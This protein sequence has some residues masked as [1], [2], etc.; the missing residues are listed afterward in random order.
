MSSAEKDA[1]VKDKLDEYGTKQKDDVKSKDEYSERLERIEKKVNEIAESREKGQPVSEKQT[2]K[3][4]IDELKLERNNLS[5]GNKKDALNKLI[6]K[7]HNENKKLIEKGLQDKAEENMA[8]IWNIFKHRESTTANR[9]TKNKRHETLGKLIEFLADRGKSLKDIT[10]QDVTDMS[11]S[12][13]GGWK[14][15]KEVLKRIQEVANS[16]YSLLE[17][18][19]KDF[20]LSKLPGAGQEGT[21]IQYIPEAN[22]L[23]K[24][25]KAIGSAV[26]KTKKFF[27]GRDP[28]AKGNYVDLDTARAVHYISMLWG[29]RGV[30]IAST[31][32]SIKYTKK[33]S[34][35]DQ[36][37][38]RLKDIKITEDKIIITL[39]D[40]AKA[41]SKNVK[42]GF[43]VDMTLGTIVIH[44]GITKKILGYD[45]YNIIKSLHEKRTSIENSKKGGEEKNPYLLTYTSF[46]GGKVLPLTKSQLDGIINNHFIRKAETKS[47][48]HTIRHMWLTSIIPKIANAAKLNEYQQLTLQGFVDKYMLAHDNASTALQR[49]K[50]ILADVNAPTGTA[51]TYTGKQLPVVTSFKQKMIMEIYDALQK[52]KLNEKKFEDI[53]KSNEK[54]FREIEG[55]DLFINKDSPFSQLPSR[56]SSIGSKKQQV[57]LS[58][59]R[60]A[61]SKEL[62]NQFIDQLPKN[63]GLKLKFL[64]GKEYAGEFIDGVIRLV[65]GKADLTTFFHENVH[66]LEA[67]VRDSGNKKL[68]KAW[69]R[70]E[71]TIGEWAKKNDSVR[72]NEFVR[73]YGDK[74]ANEYL[75]QLSAE[76]SLKKSQ[77]TTIGGR[78]RNW[79]KEL[80]SKVKSML[81]IANAKD[82]SRIFGSIA[83]KGFSTE[84][85]SLTGRKFSKITKGDLVDKQQIK[86]LE[87][88]LKD[89]GIKDI[90]ALYIKLATDL[91]MQPV[92]RD[93][94]TQSEYAVLRD[95]IDTVEFIVKSD[96]TY[97]KK[98]KPTW[99]QLRRDVASKNR[100]YGI[101]KETEKLI[102]KHIGISGGTMKNAS[103]MQMKRYLDILN[104]LGEPP[105]NYKTMTPDSIINSELAY[106][107]SQSDSKILLNPLV[108]RWM[109]PVDYVLRKLGASGVA[110]LMLDH[111][112]F[113]SGLKGVS[114]YRI[115]NAID[116][117]NKEYGKHRYH[118]GRKMFNDYMGYAMDKESRAGARIDG[119]GREFLE[120]ADNVKTSAEY[121]A[122]QEMRKMTDFFFDT[123]LEIGKATIKNPRQL[124]KWLEQNSKLYVQEYF[125]RVPTKEGKKYLEDNRNDENIVIR[126]MA[127]IVEAVVKDRNSKIDKLKS[128]YDKSKPTSIAKTKEYRKKIKELERERDNIAE[129]LTDKS[130][131]E[132]TKLRQTAERQVYDLGQLRKN[133]V[134]N[135]Y[136][137]KRVPRL[138]NVFKDGNGKEIF[139]YETNFDKV[140][141]R[142][143]NVMSNYLA[144]AKYFPSFTNMRSSFIKGNESMQRGNEGDLFAQHLKVLS[145]E[146]SMQGAY[147][148]LAVKKRIGLAESDISNKPLDFWLNQAGRYSAM[149]GLSSPMSGLKNLVIGTTNTIGIF[150]MSNYLK[151]IAFMLG[152][153]SKLVKKELQKLGAGEIGTK[154]IELT[155]F[156]DFIMRNISKMKPTEVANRF[157]SAW[158]GLLTAEQLV[159]R[160]RGDRLGLFSKMRAESARKEL[161]SKFELSDKE[162]LHLQNHG[163]RKGQHGFD[164]QAANSLNAK[165][166]AI[167]DKILHY[168]HIITQ[169]AT[170]EPFLPLWAANN[171]ISSLTLFYRMAYSGTYNIM[172]HVVQPM[173]NGNVLPMARY[174]F[175]GQVM[176]A[177]LWAIYDSIMGNPPPKINES[178]L[179]RFSVNAAKA[180][181]LGLFGF[182][183]SPFDQSL[184]SDSI[185][186]PAIIRNTNTVLTHGFNAFIA[187]FAYKMGLKKKPVDSVESF[188]KL[189][190]DMV[191]L[192][193]HSLR[194]LEKKNNPYKTNMRKLKTFKK[195]FMNKQEDGESLSDK[196]TG[197]KTKI[198]SPNSMY[199]NL[200]EEAF[201]NNDLESAA[202]YYWTTRLY[203][204]DNSRHFRG[205]EDY[206][207]KQARANV[208]SQLKNMLKGINPMNFPK[209]LD[210]G[211]ARRIRYV[212][213]R[214]MFMGK[215]RYDKK[216]Y[217]NDEYRKV[218]W[219]A[220]KTYY[221]RMRQLEKHIDKYEKHYNLDLYY[222]RGEMIDPFPI[223][224]R[225]SYGG[226]R[227]Y[228]MDERWMTVKSKQSKRVQ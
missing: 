67:F 200:I 190:T 82:V 124:E 20:V 159:N 75:T 41:G 43:S 164:G 139:M 167:R 57:G 54:Q 22:I 196:E 173:K 19:D 65:E 73:K 28:K 213:K 144:T 156:P 146:G 103:E 211:Q 210:V 207:S 137:L 12:Y 138:P 186:R 223:P 98:R 226:K 42:E 66:R 37:P 11:K 216:S 224:P 105:Y 62:V 112:Q 195:S 83:E 219:D 182:V 157:Y 90:E 114:A 91:G 117:L 44:K 69:E 135:P 165:N 7:V 158:A 63:K 6:E 225:R 122:V 179:D 192:I 119:R 87:K 26:K 79:F 77:T 101:G 221:H 52:G 125:T 99:I 215:D 193:S 188:Q 68:I 184:F 9:N 58:E 17:I 118:N 53:I 108:G 111:Y 162:I 24:S 148:E 39:Y 50:E 45:I 107:V 145:A 48:P 172:K 204:Y 129:A 27:I 120:K 136:L 205:R 60:V 121:K 21:R 212:N 92:K 175:A 149:F 151:S 134:H 59:H 201:L 174:L 168:S 127:S 64:K 202:R 166:K 25:I 143:I 147:V 113:E 155:G 2:N 153:E 55:K 197:V 220:E 206:T 227:L 70:G 180:E 84:G 104:S 176:G 132:Y 89:T 13:A 51:N 133:I 29:K 96:G 46:Q 10:M 217:L 185:M 95:H 128:A 142:Y 30:A 169:G 116:I 203:L 61:T 5:E 199:Y 47:T 15:V 16:K 31:G 115:N 209:A 86:D 32:R 74:A 94:L 141:G 93:S 35:S 198:D 177:G 34:K 36:E 131:T 106:K 152:P 130:N 56:E 33:G 23:Q 150:G 1:Q 109:L 72:W 189:A 191:P 81:G 71:K 49:R 194:T 40:K 110:D 102:K 78:L 161:K 88:A 3:T 4:L 126:Q 183:F 208:D 18:R 170:A 123:F 218:A 97:K 178:E 171:K 154:E 181:T 14:G 140:M 187:P 76:W 38:I 8:S 228:T 163:L 160:L 80:T 222:H 85:V 214:N 100:L